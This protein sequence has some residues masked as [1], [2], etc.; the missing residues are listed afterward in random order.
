M[1]VNNY[2]CHFRVVFHAPELSL[3]QPRDT[4]DRQSLARL[5][6][7]GRGMTMLRLKRLGVRRIRALDR[8]HGRHA[9]DRRRRPTLTGYLIIMGG[10]VM[11]AGIIA[12]LD[13]LGRRNERQS[14]HRRVT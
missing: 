14:R 12:L 7:C 2:E 5:G 1:Y 8:A 9:F 4:R 13:W 10:I 3:R 11:F 6:I